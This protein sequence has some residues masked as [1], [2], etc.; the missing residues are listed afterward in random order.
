M[1]TN[2]NGLHNLENGEIINYV[3]K[4]SQVQKYVKSVISANGTGGMKSKLMASEIAAECG[5]KTIIANGLEKNVLRKI[6]S[7]KEIGTLIDLKK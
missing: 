6:F 3:N 4:I 1:L 2:V 7:G 5:A